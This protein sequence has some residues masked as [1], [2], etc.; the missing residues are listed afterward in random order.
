MLQVE[1]PL[2]E[3]VLL[4]QPRMVVVLVGVHRAAEDEHRAVRVER[5][6]QRRVPREAPLLQRVAARG[7]DVGEHAG[8]HLPLRG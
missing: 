4:A 2:Q 8:A 7:D 5:T 3:Q 1:Q 6:R